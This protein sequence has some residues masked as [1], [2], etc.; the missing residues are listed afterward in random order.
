M[1]TWHIRYWTDKLGK[2]LFEEW[3]LNLDEKQ[4]KIINKKLELLEIYGNQLKMPHSKA[5]GKGL[6]E[7]RE[8][9]YYHRIYY[10]F[11]G[12][13]IIIILIAGNKRS[14]EKDIKIAR[15]RLDEI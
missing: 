1:S 11:H 10:G 13:Q 14:Q 2:N 12:K 3:L 7:L 9:I 6:F 8:Q 4:A 15:K 5:L